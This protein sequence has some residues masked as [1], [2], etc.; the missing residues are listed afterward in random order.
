MSTIDPHTGLEGFD[1]WE[2][3]ARGIACSRN[4]AHGA[5]GARIYRMGDHVTCEWC[6]A[7]S[8]N[9]LIELHELGKALG[10]PKHTRRLG[11]EDPD[12]DWDLP[13]GAAVMADFREW[14]SGPTA[15]ER[16]QPG[17]VLNL[18]REELRRAQ[19][20]GDTYWDEDGA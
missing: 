13:T 20:C 11:S 19:P 16:G 18:A 2:A 14:T 6:L 8:A 1:G 12:L 5:R 9:F 3:T 10:V 17:K 4:P 7:D 15:E